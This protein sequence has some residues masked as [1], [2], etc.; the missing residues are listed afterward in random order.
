MTW[1]R[2]DCSCYIPTQESLLNPLQTLPLF[3]SLLFH[4][5]PS[6][7]RFLLVRVSISHGYTYIFTKAKTAHRQ[8]GITGTATLKKLLNRLKPFLVSAIQQQLHSPRSQRFWKFPLTRLQVGMRKNASFIST[9]LR[10]SPSNTACYI[11]P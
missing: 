3:M 9:A 8:Q 5:S 11:P 1:Q 2:I 10:K 7:L 6:S 4:Y